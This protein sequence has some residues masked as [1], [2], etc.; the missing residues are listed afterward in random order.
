[1]ATRPLY[2]IHTIRPGEAHIGERFAIEYYRH[3][4][5]AG[6]ETRGQVIYLPQEG[7]EVSMWCREENPRAIYHNPNDP[8][9]TD[10]CMEAFLNCF[11]D[12]PAYGYIGLEMNANG[13]SHCSFGTARHTRGYIVGRGLAHPEVMVDRVELEGASWWRATCLLRRS[14]LEA[15]YGRDCTFMPGQTMR[16]NFYKCG[17]DTASP[18]WGSWAPI[19]KV[20]FHVPQLFGDIEIR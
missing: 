11:P 5:A 8:V 6:P 18:H 20:D 1:M 13:A 12:E 15:L 7:L 9:Y 3:E 16:G 10:S 17:D 14:L 19:A 2:H 4:G